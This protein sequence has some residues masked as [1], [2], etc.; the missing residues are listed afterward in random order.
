M[1]HLQRR[2]LHLRPGDRLLHRLDPH[3]PVGGREKLHEVLHIDGTIVVDVDHVEKVL[4]AL[5]LHPLVVSQYRKHCG[6]ELCHNGGLLAQR[7]QAEPVQQVLGAGDAGVE[8]QCLHL[9]PLRHR[10]AL[11]ERPQIVAQPLLEAEEEVLDCLP[12]GAHR[13]PGL[14]E[15]LLHSSG[16]CVHFPDARA[17][18]HL[19]KRIH[20]VLHLRHLQLRR[21]DL[22]GDGPDVFEKLPANCG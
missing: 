1:V 22:L 9:H 6:L 2:R 3:T 4:G 5:A 16:H 18:D 19:P 14:L 20:Q 10:I 17:T 13:S 21:L 11:V 12:R 7:V 8:A 15:D